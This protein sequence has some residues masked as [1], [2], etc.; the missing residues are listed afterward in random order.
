MGTKTGFIPLI[1]ILGVSFPLA[2]G[3]DSVGI[4]ASPDKEFYETG[5]TLIISG[6]VE[7]KKMPILALRIFDPDDS[8]LSANNV[9][10]EEDNSFSKIVFLDA[11]FYEKSGTY[12]VKI[13]YGKLDKEV[14]FEIKSDEDVEES[15]LVEQK[16]IT[17][18]LISLVTDKSQYADNDTITISGTVNTI[19]DATVLIGIH[20]PFGIPKIGRAHV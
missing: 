9:E 17:P 11:P 2:F 7:E 13:D 12:K 18:E 20:D 8:I 5:D 3:D 6:H 14:F 1:L 10:I 19:N 16:E 15:I 4:I